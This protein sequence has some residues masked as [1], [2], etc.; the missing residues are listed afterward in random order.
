MGHAGER[1]GFFERTGVNGTA[2]KLLDQARRR[3]HL[4]RP[5]IRHACEHSVL[6]GGNDTKAY[7]EMPYANSNLSHC[8]PPTRRQATSIDCLARAY[9]PLYRTTF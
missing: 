3:R 1:T 8:G 4:D 6:L 7:A 2:G 9:E 5:V